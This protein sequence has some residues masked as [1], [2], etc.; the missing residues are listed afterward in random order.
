MPASQPRHLRCQRFWDT[1]IQLLREVCA[2][3]RLH[4]GHAFDP[5]FATTE[6]LVV[7]RVLR[8]RDVVRHPAVRVAGQPEI[9]LLEPVGHEGRGHVPRAVR[10]ELNDHR[11]LHLLD[12]RMLADAIIQSL[13]RGLHALRRPRGRDEVIRAEPKARQE[14]IARRI[15]CRAIP[16]LEQR[17]RNRPRDLVQIETH[18]LARALDHHPVGEGD[19]SAGQQRSAGKGKRQQVSG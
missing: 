7:A 12:R 13:E 11:V 9:R 19:R 1:P 6:P 15:L 14:I 5:Y 8:L 18:G 4:P 3:H 16:R 17:E 2:V 10:R